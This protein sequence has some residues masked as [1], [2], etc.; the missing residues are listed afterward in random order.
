MAKQ[1]Q[2]RRFF[3]NRPIR[4]KNCMWWPCL[5][6]NRDEMSNLH[7]GYSIDAF[8][9]VSVHLA[10]WKVNDTATGS[11]HRAS[12]YCLTTIGCWLYMYMYMCLV[13]LYL[14]LK[15]CYVKPSLHLAIFWCQM[16]CLFVQILC[17]SPTSTW[18]SKVICHG[19]FVL[20]R[21]QVRGDCWYWCNCWSSLLNSFMVF[22]ATFNNILCIVAASFICG[23]NR[24]T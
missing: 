4:K 23:W 19:L 13:I 7:R 5:L 10:E 17:M 9:Q 1:F 2:R 16:I 15:Y 12:S 6:T 8:Y 21:F 18:I 11:A 24:R 14:Y 22:F 3:R 20:R